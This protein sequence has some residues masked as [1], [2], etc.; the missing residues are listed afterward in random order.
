MALTRLSNY[1]LAPGLW[2]FGGTA[3]QARWWSRFMVLSIQSD[4]LGKPLESV[5]LVG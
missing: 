3:A 4:L 5:K 2:M 1:F